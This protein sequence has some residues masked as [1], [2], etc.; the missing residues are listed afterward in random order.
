MQVTPQTHFA[1]VLAVNMTT[2]RGDRGDSYDDNRSSWNG[3]AAEIWAKWSFFS[4]F[5]PGDHSAG[6]R[7]LVPGF[8]TYILVS[9]VG[10]EL[11]FQ[12]ADAGGRAGGKRKEMCKI[13]GF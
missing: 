6:G 1:A 5:L 3:L 12:L 8:P 2:C 7:G 13:S 9:I 10:R 4:R 11:S